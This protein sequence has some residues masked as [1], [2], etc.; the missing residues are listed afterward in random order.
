MYVFA[1]R[2]NL[3]KYKDTRNIFCTSYENCYLTGKKCRILSTNDF[4][5]RQ[6]RLDVNVLEAIE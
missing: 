5:W 1:Y 2:I 4:Q 3:I 6:M